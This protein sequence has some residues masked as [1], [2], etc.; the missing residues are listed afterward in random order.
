[1]LSL[2]KHE[3]SFEAGL[4][5]EWLLSNGLGGYASSTA[6]LCNARKWHGL[7]V[8]GGP[9]LRRTLLLASTEDWLELDGERFSLST[10][11]YPGAVHPQGFRNI[12][13]FGLD[14]LPRARFDFED[15]RVVK[16]IA[17]VQGENTLVIRYALFLQRPAKLSV[18]PFIANRRP[19]ELSR[20]VPEHEVK[21]E[22]R[23][24]TLSFPTTSL[25]ISSDLAEFKP[26]PT[27]FHNIR[28]PL[29][30]ERG[31]AFEEDLFSPGGF[32][33][34]LPKGETAFHIVCTTEAASHPRPAELIELERERLQRTA[35]LFYSNS[36]LRESELATHLAIAAD[37]FL[38]RT[39]EG[40]TILAGY[41]WFGEWGRDAMISLP[42]LLLAGKRFDDARAVLRRFASLARPL[43][44]NLI[45]P[46]GAVLN[47]A[48]A[49]L[50]FI[51]ACHEYA[52]AS[53]DLSFVEK[54]LYQKIREIIRSY[55]RGGLPGI[56]LE[57][58]GLLSLAAG[59]TWMDARVE[60]QPV[61]PRA[62]K[63]VEINALWYNALR[64]GEYFANSSGDA[65]FARECAEKARLA[66][67][68][69]RKFWNEAELCLYDVIEPNDASIRPNQLL[70]LSLPFRLLEEEKELLVLKK[71]WRE[72]YTPLG[73]RT[74]SPRDPKY[75]PF[76][77][78]SLR[79]RDAAYHQ[80][81]V[82]PWLLGLFL[83]AMRRLLPQVELAPFLQPF[84]EHLRA[85]GLGS[86]SELF[87]ADSL[88]PDGCFSQAWSVAEILRAKAEL[89]V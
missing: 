46:E 4:R 61:T 12:T 63:P 53:G 85:H 23:E 31:E 15:A 34:A 10:N 60:G 1:M 21:Q 36:K 67:S 68:S 20:G 43:V 6:I 7:L 80:G 57:D 14:P 25:R 39:K 56:S 79:E 69:F 5:R 17:L 38:A 66:K 26:N 71:V 50:W 8:S 72:L 88:R 29:D 32:E 75:R 41:P 28:Y 55:A 22:W 64:I 45:T 78:G 44:P 87:E 9:S 40:T 77:R 18:A 16:T 3:L 30:E 81:A 76:Y 11:A 24:V 51:N 65:S 48:D 84:E 83:T 73:L 2:G 58:D 37:S 62:G 19:D 54:E 13:G 33:L 70:A 35:A 74:L 59:L 82:W 89:G 27:S 47:A 42:G 86:V 52:R 49:S